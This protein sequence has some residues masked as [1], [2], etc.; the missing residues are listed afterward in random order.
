[1]S[2]IRRYKKIKDEKYI[3]AYAPA[4]YELNT[5]STPE[6][7][8]VPRPFSSMATCYKELI[9]GFKFPGYSQV[10]SGGPQIGYWTTC[11]YLFA[12]K[13]WVEEVGFDEK[14]SFNTEEFYL[15]L[16]TFSKGWKIYGIQALD[17]YHHDSHKQPDGTTTR[18]IKRPWADDRKE[19]YWAHVKEST[20]RLSLLMSGQMDVDKKKV[21]EFF[22]HTGIS[23]HYLDFIP[24]YSSHVVIPN[25]SLGIPPRREK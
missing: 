16:R 19:A 4:D 3:I 21:E 12:P 8:K 1:L 11:C 5:D 2:A 18:N 22:E 23:K 24:N 17:V 25:R 10:H 13:Q 15:S 20:D 14:S 9:P 6:L 7:Q